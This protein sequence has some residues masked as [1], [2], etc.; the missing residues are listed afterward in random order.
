MSSVLLSVADWLRSD[1]DLIIGFVNYRV[2]KNLD[3]LLIMTGFMAPDF[4]RELVVCYQIEDK[5]II[6]FDYLQQNGLDLT[7]FEIAGKLQNENG[8]VRFYRQGNVGFSRKKLQPLKTTYFL[9]QYIV[10]NLHV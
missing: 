8:S 4:C 6:L 5:Q 3:L 1:S 2:D 7:A 10:L 9:P